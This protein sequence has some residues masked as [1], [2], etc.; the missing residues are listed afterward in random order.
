MDA[1]A[2]FPKTLTPREGK[3]NFLNPHEESTIFGLFMPE[4]FGPNRGVT[5]TVPSDKVG[6]DDGYGTWS[7]DPL[8]VANDMDAYLSRMLYCSDA[9]DMRRAIAWV[10]EHEDTWRPLWLKGKADDLNVEADRLENEARNMRRKA[11]ALYKQAVE[12]ADGR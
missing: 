8:N 11:D 9:A 10:R 7:D 4:S 1:D 6:W 5:Y 2:G 12:F 3:F